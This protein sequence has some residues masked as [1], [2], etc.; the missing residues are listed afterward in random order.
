MY[1]SAIGQDSH[2]FE[3]EGSSKPLVLGGAIINGHRGLMGNSDADV[4]LHAITNA[5]S[6]ISGVNILGKISDDLCLKLGITDSRVYLAEA[7][8]TL[9]VWKLLHVSISVEARKPHLAEHIARIRQS[10]ASLL[11]LSIESVG[12]TATSGEGLTEFGKG[13]GIQALVIISAFNLNS[14]IS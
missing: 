2:R 4:I 8:K 9:G 12:L 5:I 1:I 11:S 7:L 3:P 14:P 10:I 13:E 6:G